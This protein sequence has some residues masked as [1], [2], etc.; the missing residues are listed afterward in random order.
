MWVHRYR[1]YIHI[2]KNYLSNAQQIQVNNGS[3]TVTPN[4]GF[5]FQGNNNYIIYG[6]LNEVD[7]FYNHFVSGEGIK[8]LFL[9]NSSDTIDA[10][11]VGINPGAASFKWKKGQNVQYIPED[12]EYIRIKS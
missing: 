11:G 2:D 5:N 9:C 4:V 12:D 7:T 1:A 8:T 6:F 3:Y 10:S